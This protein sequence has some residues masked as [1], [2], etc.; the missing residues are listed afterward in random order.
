MSAIIKVIRVNHDEKGA[1]IMGN[2]CIYAENM[3]VAYK[4]ESK[5]IID[6]SKREK[7]SV[8]CL[9]TFDLLA[10]WLETVET[11]EKR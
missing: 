11:F 7:L 8:E 3:T 10:E 1:F 9:E 6:L 4:I 2:D 5:W